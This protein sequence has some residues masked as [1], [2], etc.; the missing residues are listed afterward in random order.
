MGKMFWTICAPVEDVT[1]MIED[2]IKCTLDVI[3]V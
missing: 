1:G 2:S 3:K